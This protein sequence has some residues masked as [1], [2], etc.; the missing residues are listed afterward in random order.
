MIK[1]TREI[2]KW[3]SCLRRS[4]GCIITNKY[5]E[6]LSTGYNGAISG[7]KSCKERGVCYREQNNI[8]SGKE[9]E[10]CYGVHA[11]QNALLQCTKNG[12][13]TRDAILFCTHQPCACCLR[14]IGNSGIK[15][16]YYL[17]NYPDEFSSSLINQINQTSENLSN[18]GLKIIQI[19]FEE[20]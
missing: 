15:R 3:S 14:M 13:S 7:L 4:V 19:K 2:A 9:T 18:L 16:V 5:Y 6:I 8:P 12:K 17:E 10:R 1:Q 11:E 20:I